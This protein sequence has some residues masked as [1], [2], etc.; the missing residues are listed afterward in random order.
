M[1]VYLSGGKNSTKLG[2]I[3]MFLMNNQD[4]GVVDASL[5]SNYHPHNQ[6]DLLA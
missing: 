6:N 1:F 5:T 4:I 3:K 2:I